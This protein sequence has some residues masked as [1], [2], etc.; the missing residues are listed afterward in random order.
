MQFNIIPYEKQRIIVLGTSRG[1]VNL[2]D[3]DTGERVANNF[4]LNGAINEILTI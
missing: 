2:F 1:F 4:T 3:F